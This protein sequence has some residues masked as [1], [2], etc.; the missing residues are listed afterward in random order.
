[1]ARYQYPPYEFLDAKIREVEAFVAGDTLDK[2]TSII[3]KLENDAGLTPERYIR[4]YPE[5]AGT[6]APHHPLAVPGIKERRDLPLV[7]LDDQYSD[8]Y[9]V[10]FGALDF[11]ETFWGALLID[12][13]GN[14]IHTWKLSTSHLPGNTRPGYGKNMYGV[15]IDSEGAITFT[16]QE[17]GGGI[18]KVDVCGDEIWNLPGRY[19]HTVAPGD[20][21]TFWSFTGLQTQLDQDLVQISSETGK[22]L[23]TIHMKEVRDKNPDVH[24]WNLIYPSSEGHGVNFERFVSGNMSHGNDISPLPANLAPNFEQFEAGDLLIS[25]AATNL[26]FVLDPDSLEIKWWRVGLADGQHDPDWRKNGRISI[27]DNEFRGGPEKYSQIVSVD[28][29]T[30]ESKVVFD[31]EKIKFKSLANG[32][33]QRTVYGTRMITSAFQGWAFEVD[34][35]GKVVFS[36]INV[37]DG[38]GRKSLHLSDAYHLPPD[39]FSGKPWKKCQTLNQSI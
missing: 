34:D 4:N 35:T 25:Y 20:D 12:A 7:Y 22:I 18:V 27:Y 29:E 31:G 30:Y 15:N 38:K 26:L 5:S 10:I 2:N 9:R 39:F 13:N 37:F 28:P 19:H 33:H 8:G 16:M 32:M 23:K 1:M 14:A 3:E 21:G 6:L 36:F 17:K 24:I 11:E